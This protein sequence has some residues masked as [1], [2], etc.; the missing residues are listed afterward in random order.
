MNLVQQAEQIKLIPDAVLGPMQQNPTVF[1]PF[2]VLAEMQR[3]EAMRNA[4]R[5][6]GD[7]V[8]QK[9]VAEEMREKFNPAPQMQQPNPQQQMAQPMPQPGM[10]GAPSMRL[11]GGG[12]ATLRAQTGLLLPPYM[13]GGISDTIGQSMPEG[14]QRLMG[15]PGM[16][17]VDPALANPQFPAAAPFGSY[18]GEPPVTQEQLSKKFPTRSLKAVKEET[19]AQRAPDGLKEYADLLASQEKDARGKKPKIGEILMNLGLAMAASKRPD[20]AGAVGEGGLAALH[21]YSKQRDANLERADSLM[22]QRMGVAEARQRRDDQALS[23]ARSVWAQEQHNNNANMQTLTASERAQWN[24]KQ[25]TDRNERTQERY[26]RVQGMRDKT[27]AERDDARFAATSEEN[28]R[29]RE[30]RERMSQAEI[31]ARIQ[32]ANLQMGQ[33][34][35]RLSPILQYTDRLTDNIHSAMRGQ[36]AA[37]NAA[38]T[39]EEKAATKKALERLAKQYESIAKVQAKELV[40][41]YPGM[42]FE[43]L[44]EADKEPEQAGSDVQFIVDPVSGK[45]IKNPNYKPAG[46]PTAA[47]KDYSKSRE[48]AVS[49]IKEGAQVAATPPGLQSIIGMAASFADR[50]RKPYSA[51]HP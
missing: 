44:V 45:P 43:G 1:P 27:A 29:D 35:D 22:K 51:P 6:T 24:Q 21:G 20:F 31:K 25:E 39:D 47:P 12:L 36:Q 15:M 5:A 37:M 23:D 50:L 18:A 9:T 17:P 42:G 2:L 40:K 8:Q 46:S 16:P 7:P 48:A 3:R 41:Q 14:L 32:A 33:R 4:S 38:T 11:A 13:S 34:P 19:D 26:E 28:R 10:P 30:S 49:A